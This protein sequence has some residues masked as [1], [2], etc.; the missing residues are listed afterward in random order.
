MPQAQLNAL[1]AVAHQ[2]PAIA[3]ELK[4]ANELKALELRLKIQYEWRPSTA[5][6]DLDELAG[7][8]KKAN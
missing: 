2:L 1:L 8:M 3:K 5:V 6:E 4:K 7:I